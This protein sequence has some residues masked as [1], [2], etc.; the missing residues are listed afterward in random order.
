MPSKTSLDGGIALVTGAASGIGKETALAF[1]EAGVRGI[2]FA[3]ANEQGARDAAEESK[4]LS[5][6]ADY[7]ALALKV[8]I[9][10]EDSV[11]AMVDATIKE[12]GRIDYS[13]NSA[14]IG[15]VAP[16]LTPDVNVDVF[17]KT[18]DINIKGTLL[19]VRAVSKAMST[20]EPLTYTSRRYGTRSLG[21]G[22]IVNL[23]SINSFMAAPG[24]SPYI[25]SKHAVVGITKSAALDCTK[26]HIRVN[27]VCPSFT[28]TAMM[29]AGYKRTPG[30][31]QIVNRDTPLRRSAVA[32]EIADYIIFLCSPSASYINGTGLTIDSGITLTAHL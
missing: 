14:G 21:R 20:Q 19:C 9:A 30:L 24:M 25:A 17:T 5:K 31:E 1:A 7:C 15:N 2:V 11:Q 23:G 28:D 3:D 29:R 26:H 16:A 6:N 22:C 10:S 12:F 18:I 27:S 8:D 32:E 4:S 13:V